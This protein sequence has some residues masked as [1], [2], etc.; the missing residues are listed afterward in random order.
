MAAEVQT[1]MDK[2]DMKRLLMKS[3]SEPVNCA[4]G[5]G[6][7][8]TMGLLLLDK[9]K[10]PKGVEKEL[11]KQTPD[12][13]NTR[14]GTA[15]VDVETDPKQV[16]FYI[17]KPVSSM[18]KKL[19][20]TLKG[21]GFTKVKIVLEDG[22]DVEAASDEE[23]LPRA[24]PGQPQ[25]A[26][27]Q[28]GAPPPAPPEVPP[29]PPPAAAQPDATPP[30]APPAPA[31]DAAPPA[32]P[33]DLGALARMLA[34]L[35]KRLAQAEASLQGQLKGLAIQAQAR[36]KASDA[37]GASAAIEALREALDSSGAAAAPGAPPAA[38]APVKAA[39]TFLTARKAWLATRQKVETDISKLQSSFSSAFKDHD[40][41]ADLE[42]AFQT[43]VESVLGKLDAELAEKLDAV[44]KTADPA[45]HAKLVGEARKI[46]QRYQD[47]VDSDPTL[48]EIDSNPFVPL[49]IQKTLT[50]TLSALSKALG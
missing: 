20:K 7:D 25:A 30:A 4:F 11:I 16:L 45:Q 48:T 10:G 9:V 5:Q 37:Q 21:T 17:N 1:G 34:D 12:A 33:A 28:A 38:P 23:E 39:A 8:P 50:T 36:L 49:A 47:F 13:K 26:P 41:A 18:A 29:A 40:M 14:Y 31:S 15:F 24:P 35:I 32:A 6:K 42:A 19:V 3:K 43:R 22:T 2:Q 27:S 46:M 44:S